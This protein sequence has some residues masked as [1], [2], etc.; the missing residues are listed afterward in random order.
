MKVKE[1]IMEQEQK[2]A[3]LPMGSQIVSNPE[4]VQVKTT[5]D[6][7]DKQVFKRYRNRKLYS[8][9]ESRYVTLSDIYEK[10]V[11]DG[12][13]IL[14]LG[15]KGEDITSGILLQAIAQ[16]AQDKPELSAKII[17]MV[18]SSERL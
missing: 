6:T 3:L 15:P 13:E 1:H 17:E 18:K 10:A 4:V 8:S 16:V 12:N 5:I 2:E 14:V 9:N 11:T 7:E